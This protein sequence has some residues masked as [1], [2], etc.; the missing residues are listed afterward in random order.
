MSIAKTTETR[1]RT[2]GKF[3]LR[4]MTQAQKRPVPSGRVYPWHKWR[5]A[6]LEEVIFARRALMELEH[7]FLQVVL[8][9]APHPH[10][11]GHMIR[12]V[13]NQNPKWYQDFVRSFWGWHG[14]HRYG[15]QLKKKQVVAAL[16]RVCDK[17]IVL[18]VG[19]EGRI[20]KHLKD[21]WG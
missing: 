5:E 12:S 20:L 19:Y 16:R 7:Q 14:K 21:Y 9:P 17:N 18:A 8:T 11:E 3:L 13:V 2:E 1:R 6:T 10:F 4:V 15:C